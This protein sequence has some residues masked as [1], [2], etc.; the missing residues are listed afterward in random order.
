M[1]NLISN[2]L[3]FTSKNNKTHIEIGTSDIQENQIGIYIKDNGVGFDN[4]Y[5]HKMFGVFERLHNNQDFP[6]T[7][8]GLANVKRI[9][10][11][12]KGTIRGEGKLNEGATFFITLPINL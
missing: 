8:I 5:A 7:G 10:R 4:N 11:S 6:G 9:I 1:D 3:K 12:H 2:A